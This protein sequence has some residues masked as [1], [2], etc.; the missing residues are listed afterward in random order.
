MQQAPVY[1]DVVAEVSQFLAGRITAAVA[2]QI[3]KE[4]IL[5]DPGIGFGKTVE[6]NISLL[7]HLSAFSSLNCPLV[8]GTSRKSFIGALTN[9]SDP[10]ARLPGSL[11]T[12]PAML[13]AD[14]AIVRIHDVAATRQFLK[15]HESCCKPPP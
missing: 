11:A 5:I 3:P 14:V 7:K 2:A 6:H 13:N 15:I 12:L 9:V 4:K 10:Q 1:D 8:V